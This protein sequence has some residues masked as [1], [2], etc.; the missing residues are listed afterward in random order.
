MRGV[1]MCLVL[2]AHLGIGSTIRANQVTGAWLGVSMFFTLSGFLICRQVLV[3]WQDRGT[4]D[5]KA[6]WRRRANRLFPAAFTC[7]AVV[8]LCASFGWI[9]AGPG[10]RHEIIATIFYANNWYRLRV[11][12]NGGPFSQFWSL[13]VE[14]QFYVL[15]PL[16]FVLLTRWLGRRAGYAFGGLAIVGF[17][18][19]AVTA[20]SR[21]ILYVYIATHTRMAEILIGV[22]FAYVAVSP[23]YLALLESRRFVIASQ[24][25]GLLGVAVYVTLWSTVSQYHP[26]SYRWPLWVNTT[27]TIALIMCA[28]APGPVSRALAP[29]PLRWLGRITYSLYIYHALIY[30]ILTPERL[31]TDNTFAISAVRIGATLFVGWLSHTFIEERLRRIQTTRYLRLAASY[32]VAAVVLVVSANALPFVTIK[33][34]VSYAKIGA[35]GFEELDSQAIETSFRLVVIGD[36]LAAESLPGLH[37]LVDPRPGSY[38]VAAYTIPGCP[39]GGVATLALGGKAISPDDPCKAYYFFAPSRAWRDGARQY[40]IQGGIPNLA[41]RLDHRGNWVHLGQPEL[42]RRELRRLQGVAERALVD[43][44]E[45]VD[46]YL[47]DP[48]VAIAQFRQAEAAAR[49]QTIDPDQEVWVPLPKDDNPPPVEKSSGKKKSTGST[50]TTTSIPRPTVVPDAPPP[51]PSDAELRRRVARF[52]QLVREVA[53]KHKKIHLHD[54]GGP[55]DM[56]DWQRLLPEE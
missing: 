50:T 16:L 14:E 55:L 18:V 44:T 35:G 26:A 11:M 36:Q 38:W 45:R 30:L 34:P 8:M 54:G 15:F 9:K 39:L 46:W 6:F 5:M 43:P 32:G 53:S 25:A 42:D 21:E 48:E 17:A 1:G 13:A 52:N 31:G 33:H 3:G 27:A 10:F 29:R 24:V 51:S 20:N 37:D 41:D 40:V 47:L 28:L 49:Q 22:A 23:R 19:T 7:I 12:T 4:V 2:L 56:R